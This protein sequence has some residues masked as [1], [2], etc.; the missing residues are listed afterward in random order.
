MTTTEAHTVISIVD[1]ANIKE[2]VVTQWLDTHGF[3]KDTVDEVVIRVNGDFSGWENKMAGINLT[4]GTRVPVSNAM[5]L[6]AISS[7]T[8]VVSSRFKPVAWSI[9]GDP[10][11]DDLI[12][13]DG[14]EVCVIHMAEAHSDADSAHTSYKKLKALFTALDELDFVEKDAYLFTDN[15]FKKGGIAYNI[16]SNILAYQGFDEVEQLI[17]GDTEITSRN[18]FNVSRFFANFIIRNEEALPV[19]PA[20]IPLVQRLLS[21]KRPLTD[22]WKDRLSA[23]VL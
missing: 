17:F 11:S 4:D 16:L 6:R 21:E 10:E 13:V 1:G 3:D 8:P 7:L 12:D 9:A 18:A 5:I 22:F 14:Q 15:L 2:S 19:Q 23:I 20:D